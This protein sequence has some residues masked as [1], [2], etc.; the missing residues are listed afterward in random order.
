LT[1]IILT[2]FT[3]LR[4]QVVTAF[5]LVVGLFAA[6]SLATLAAL[7]RQIDA[8][9]LVDIA[10]RLELTASQMHMQAMNYDA[11]APRDYPTYYRDVELFYRDLKSQMALFDAVV[12]GFMTGDFNVL[13]ERPADWMQPARDPELGDAVAGLEQAWQAHRDGLTA[14][15]GED[16]EEPRLEWAAEYNIDH[17]PQVEDATAALA[18]RLRDWARSEHRHLRDL[19]IGLLGGATVVA[20][21]LLAILQIYGL[22]P[23][24]RALAGVHRVT[25]GAFGHQ[26]PVAGAAEM[27]ELAAGFNAL[28]ARLH[29]LFRLLERLERGDDLDEVVRFLSEDFRDLL[30]FDWIGVVLVTPDNATVRL[31]ASALD[32]TPEAGTKPL[33][34]LDGTLLEKALAGGR[35][36][37]IRDMA[38]TAAA[39]PRY[40]FLRDIAKRALADVI[41]LPVAAESSIPAVVAFATRAPGQYDEAHLRF[42]NNIAQLISLSFGRTVRLA[43]R[44][45]LASIGEFASGIAHELR[46]PLAT[47]TLALDHF[48]QKPAPDSSLRRLQLARQEARRMQQMI[49]DMLLYAKPLRLAWEPVNLFELATDTV[50]LLLA[51]PACK[52]VDIQVQQSC[53]AAGQAPFV[54]GDRERLRQI[55][56]NLIMNACEAAVEQST[57]QVSIRPQSGGR[58][59]VEIQNLGEPI[60]PAL[61]A[62]IFEPFV[63]GKRRGTGLGLAIV[64]RL[65]LLHG[66]DVALTST[67]AGNGTVAILNLPLMANAPSQLPASIPAQINADRPA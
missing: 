1:G 57:I 40:E 46:T 2:L 23:L 63:S 6:A 47:L 5:V 29:L 43:E 11:N 51:Q 54:L 18:A 42:L 30:R 35:P 7:Q 22:R 58:L 28:S 48:A 67:P 15:L 24:R 32:G 21:G 36:L 26:I 60:P 27:R 9:A 56:T 65:S 8:D 33:F 12:T 3:S 10:A 20:L 34:R 38:A 39:N 66:G 16:P 17:L 49:E 52:A 45:R 14:A 44:R 55:L 31:E 4:F 62:K 13:L 61:R 53:T 37:H 19:A 41:F 59:Q 25:D 64:R 50:Q